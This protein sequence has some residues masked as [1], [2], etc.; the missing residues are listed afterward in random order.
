MHKV[1]ELRT[2]S[3]KQQQKRNCY[4]EG[5]EEQK[6]DCETEMIDDDDHD[7]CID[8]CVRCVSFIHSLSLSLSLQS[9]FGVVGGFSQ[10]VIHGRGERA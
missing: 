10:I 8:A 1:G 4:V 7:D 5:S 6:N 9:A 2:S 3:E